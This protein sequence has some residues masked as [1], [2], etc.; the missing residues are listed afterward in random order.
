LEKMLFINCGTS[1]IQC[2][3]V[4]VCVLYHV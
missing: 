1:L 3:P 4:V 2:V